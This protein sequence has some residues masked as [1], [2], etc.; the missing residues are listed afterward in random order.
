MK[1]Q[2]LS[3]ALLMATSL[4]AGDKQPY[5]IEFSSGL[6]VFDDSAHLKDGAIHGVSATFYEKESYSY[7]LQIG[8]E[9]LPSI[10][11]E[12][13]VLD[14]DIDRYYLNMV[15]DGEEELSVTP[16][17]LIGGGYEQLSAVYESFPDTKNQAFVNAGIGFRYRLSDYFNISL[18][19]KAIGKIESKSVDYVTKVGLDIMFGGRWS[20]APKMIEGLGEETPKESVK[21]P[22]LKTAKKPL[23]VTSKDKKKKWITPE[24][25]EEMFS[26]TKEPSRVVKEANQPSSKMEAELRALKDQMAKNEALWAAKLSSLEAALATKLK[27]RASTNRYRSFQRLE[28]EAEARHLKKIAQTKAKIKKVKASLKAL[29]KEKE[30]A[31]EKGVQKVEKPQVSKREKARLALEKRKKERAAAFARKQ[32]RAAKIK[33]QKLAALKAKKEKIALAKAKQREAEKKRLEALEAKRKAEVAAYKAQ[34]EKTDIL[35]IANGMAVFA[36]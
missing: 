6:T 25:V 8:Y 13:I 14:S 3:M 35:H 5:H 27:E 19:T 28:R 4:V 21:K 17:L 2:I 1:K 31:V 9:H 26:R 22:L 15:V 10:A 32:A 29:D 7:G 20:K 11:Y 12:T 33:A 36:D 34:Q 18:E 16:Y 23:V 30:I 24:V